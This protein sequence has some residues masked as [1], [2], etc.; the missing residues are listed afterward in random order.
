MKD[1]KVGARMPG[2]RDTSYHADIPA[3][4]SLLIKSV[5]WFHPPPSCWSSLLRINLHP[6]V[7]LCSLQSMYLFSG[8]WGKTLHHFTEGYRQ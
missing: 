3:F 8:S 7:N 1:R 5:N 4:F 2:A 6:S